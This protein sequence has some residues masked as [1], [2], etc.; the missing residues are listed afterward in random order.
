MKTLFESEISHF[1]RMSAV[2]IQLIFFQ[3]QKN[4]LNFSANLNLVEDL[5]NIEIMK[6]IEIGG[7]SDLSIKPNAKK[8]SLAK[9]LPSLL[10]KDPNDNYQ[11][12][13]KSLKDLNVK[14]KEEVPF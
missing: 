13:I 5:K 12:E 11:Q 14:L 9:Q 7:E 1:S 3:A 2:Y 4:N 8:Q 6:Q 10:S